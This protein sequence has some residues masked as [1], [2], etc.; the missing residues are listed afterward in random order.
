MS[1]EQTSR[2]PGHEP[3]DA[4]WWRC[5]ETKRPPHEILDTLVHQLEDDQESRYAAYR[6]YAKLMGSDPDMFGYDDSFAVMQSESVSQNELA[7]TIETLHAQVFKNR[8]VP[9]VSVSE[10]DWDEGQR[11]KAYSRWL[12]G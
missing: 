7:N 8:I 4:E 11:A 10:A 1:K 2:F 6:E 5:H 9:A 3:V 12:E